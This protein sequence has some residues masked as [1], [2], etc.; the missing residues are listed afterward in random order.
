[1]AA[2]TVVHYLNQ[3]FGGIGGEDVADTPVQARD[4]LRQILWGLFK[5]LVF[6][7]NLAIVVNRAYDHPEDTPGVVLAYATLMLGVSMLACVVPTRRALRVEPTEALR[8]DA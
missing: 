1:M 5:K 7:D 2:I 4:G 8:T 6:A 3:F